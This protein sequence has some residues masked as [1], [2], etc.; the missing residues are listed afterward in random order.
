[1]FTKSH[2]SSMLAHPLR[3]PV[4]R[5]QTCR[6]TVRSTELAGEVAQQFRAHT[7]PTEAPFLPSIYFESFI[8]SRNSSYRESDAL[9]WPL[10]ATACTPTGSP[11]HILRNF[12]NKPFKNSDVLRNL[13]HSSSLRKQTQYCIFKSC[14]ITASRLTYVGLERQ[15]RH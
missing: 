6:L 13:R 9:F 12:K 5:M 2:K 10:C 15:R 8:G 3:I 7:A 1:M 14:K 4:L 11:I